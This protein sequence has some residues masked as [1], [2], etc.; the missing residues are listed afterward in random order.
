MT[1]SKKQSI[2][3]IEPFFLQRSDA[4]ASLSISESLL[5]ILVARG[6]A[7]KPRKITPGRSGW[8]VDDLREFARTRPVSDLLPPPG[9][10]YG[11][12]GKPT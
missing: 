8:H 7:P 6:E 5:D 4:A 3:K 1:T 10:G 2:V 9:C 12:A 11:R